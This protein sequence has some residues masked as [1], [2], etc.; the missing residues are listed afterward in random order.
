MAKVY[1]LS[2]IGFFDKF[3]GEYTVS[4]ETIYVN[5]DT[6]SSIETH[7]SGAIVMLKT[8][9]ILDGQPITGYVVSQT[10]AQVKTLAD[11]NNSTVNA[12]LAMAVNGAVAVPSVNTT[13]YATKAG[14]L[15]MTI[16]DPTV[17]THDGLRLTFIATTAQANTLT[18]TTGFGAG[19]ASLDVATFGGAI[20]DNIVIEAYQGKWYVVSSRNVTL[21]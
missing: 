21:S 2:K 1:A 16:V 3:G 12:V 8:P 4:S 11:A 6:V 15:A 9:Q 17:T 5:D 13:I 10:P 7:A 14:V 18:N 20:G 19:G